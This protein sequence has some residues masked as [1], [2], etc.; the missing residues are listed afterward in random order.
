MSGR[1]LR[2]V[3]QYSFGKL[4]LKVGNQGTNVPINFNDLRSS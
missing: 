4:P 1:G 3:F 2:A